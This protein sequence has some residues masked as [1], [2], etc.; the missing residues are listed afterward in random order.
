MEVP[1]TA[2]PEG[3]SVS[4]GLSPPAFAHVHMVTHTGALLPFSHRWEHVPL[5]S[6]YSQTHFIYCN[7]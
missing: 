6:Q 3:D 2:R 4:L 1:F 7:G 5:C